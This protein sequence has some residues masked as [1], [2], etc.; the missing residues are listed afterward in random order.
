MLSR[1]F[2]MGIFGME[3]FP[4]EVE[5]D[6]SRG[7]PAFE[8]VGL[9]DAAVRESRDR[10]RAAL[11]NC[12][13]EFPVSR[14]T[15]NLAPADQKKTGPIYD[16]PILLSLLCASA[17]ISV[18]QTELKESLFLGELSLSG[19]LRPMQGVLPMAIKAQKE[20]FRA[21][22]VPAG[23]ALE[24]AAVEG[25]SVYAV[26]SVPQLLAHF[27]GTQPI[28]PLAPALPPAS[29]HLQEP[30]F[31]D[32][33]GLSDVKRAVE[34]AACGGHN[35]LMIGPPGS[36][37]S[38]IAK[39]IPSILPDMTKE[40]Q[41]ETTMVH[42]I[43]GTIPSGHALLPARPFRAPHHTISPAGLSGG[44]TIPKPGELSLAHHGVLFLDE[45]PEFSRGTIELLR[46][47][48]EDG[49]VAISRAAGR[50]VYP[51]SVMLVAA[52]NPCPC[53]FFG[54]PSK[55]CTCTPSAVFKYLSRIS[56]PMLDR[57]D[58]HIEVPAVPF[59]AFDDTAPAESS[60]EIRR[61]V[62][63]ARKIQSARFAGT[64]ITCNARI[65]PD[66]LREVCP[67]DAAARA[68]FQSAFENFGFS[69]RTYDRVLKVAR[70]IAD[71]DGSAEIRAHHAAEAVQYRTLDRKY[72][73]RA[74]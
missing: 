3:A 14:I 68:V 52:M 53:G 70:T 31:S 41:L 30:D 55:R 43:A 38:M 8:I 47:P 28:S 67:M 27:S 40:E 46:Q 6:L 1:V 29:V 13:F 39:R 37:K 10:V 4:V 51:C 20:G 45:L 59:S 69:A 57:F 73:A 11:K 74:R 32:V 65:T 54:H 50:A 72:W 64:G 9:P 58:L 42:S 21:L 15:V 49:A 60:A 2:S 33:R 24:G 22:Y 61:R 66:R 44:G 19:K 34:I 62:D 48:I 71:M 17:Q 5:T 35:L 56:G 7:L 12:G 36:G 23:N 63:A 25:L 26:Q 18:P 16:L